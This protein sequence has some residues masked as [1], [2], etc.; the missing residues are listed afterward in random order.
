MSIVPETFFNLGMNLFSPFAPFNKI[1]E[2]LAVKPT[3]FLGLGVH[4]IGSAGCNLPK[5]YS[6]TS[7]I[8]FNSS[9]LSH[10]L[11]GVLSV[12]YRRSLCHYT[13]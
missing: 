1:R 7:P 11:S 9:L 10:T 5:A 13:S 12:L 2:G 3:H 4:V 8:V 6:V